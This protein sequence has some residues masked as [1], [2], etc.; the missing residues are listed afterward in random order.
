MNLVSQ[1]AAAISLGVH[2]ACEHHAPRRV[3]GRE[4]KFPQKGGDIRAID[5]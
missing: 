4:R 3:I 5:A 2:A 1:I